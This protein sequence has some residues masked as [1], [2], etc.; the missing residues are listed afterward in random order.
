[1]IYVSKQSKPVAHLTLAKAK[2]NELFEITHCRIWCC[3]K[4]P[5]FYGAHY[6]LTIVDDANRAAWVCL[7]REN[8]ELASHVQNFWLW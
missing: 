1:V 6:F 7:I 5:S 2:S 3:Y 8:S 4:I